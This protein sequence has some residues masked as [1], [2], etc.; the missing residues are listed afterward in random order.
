MANTDT[1]PYFQSRKNV[2]LDSK[3]SVL[4]SEVAHVPIRCRRIT[5]K[6]IEDL[7][8]E[9]YRY[10]GKGITFKDLQVRFSFK[11][12]KGQRSLKYFHDGHVLF[13]AGDL[14]S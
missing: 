4:D 6:A 5:R 2:L 8:I 1:F 9:K 14:N 3:L 11:K 12:T 7:A 13:T 10:C